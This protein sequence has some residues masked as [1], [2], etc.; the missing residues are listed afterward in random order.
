MRVKR[1]A[2]V[3]K[4]DR[5]NFTFL[6]LLA[7]L[8]VVISHA[9]LFRTNNKADEIFST[10]SVYNLGDHAVNVFFVLSG[11]TVAASIARSRDVLEFVIARLLRVFPALVFCTTLVVMLGAIV[12]NYKAAE[13][14]T[15]PKVLVYF[16]SAVSLIQTSA[17]LP[18]V[19][20]SNPHPS[21]V[22]GSLWTLKFELFCYILLAVMGRCGFLTKSKV[23]PVL[24]AT[25]VP[26]SG[27]LLL[28]QTGHHLN[29]FEQGGRLW[30]CFSFGIAL[31]VFREH[32][33]LSGSIAAG[34]VLL[35]V[36][37]AKT[38]WERIIDPIA[39]GY[40]AVWIGSFP[41]GR[42]RDL[43]N[44]I[45][46]SYGVYIF[47]WPISQTLVYAVPQISTG[48]IVASSILFSMGMALL[49]WCFVERP[50]LRTRMMVW[51]WVGQ[52]VRVTPLPRLGHLFTGVTRAVARVRAVPPELN[53]EC[54]PK[55]APQTAQAGLLAQATPHS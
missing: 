20:L 10:V 48:A 34:L 52:N 46:L 38:G 9:V 23:A 8:A 40:C 41:L 14:L 12:S 42:L 17:D 25:W 37:A 54:E 29:S 13:Y 51:Q 26:I 47:G 43:T 11:L 30:L 33:K 44:R 55:S 31:F 18:G 1:V 49:S 28:H 19:F 24:F 5:N 39:L 45:D 16:F 3:L 15:D 7:A 2:D 32:V 36:L 21:V 6:R 35:A 50:A 53:S 4:P 22:N 27:Y